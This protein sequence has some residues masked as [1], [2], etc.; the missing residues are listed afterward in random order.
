MEAVAAPNWPETAVDHIEFL[1]DTTRWLESEDNVYRYA[2]FVGRNKEGVG[3]FPHNGLLAEN[4]ATTALGEVY[5]AIP[6]NG[7]QYQTEVNI[8]A[9]GAN[10]IQ[11]FSYTEIS[12][13]NSIVAA[14]ADGAGDSRLDFDFSIEAAQTYQLE[15]RV[16]SASNASLNIF[17]GQEAV[18]TIQNINTGSVSNWQTIITD[19]IALDTGNNSLSIATNSNILINSVKLVPVSDNSASA[20]G[21]N[22]IESTAFTP[23]DDPTWTHVIPLA[24]YQMAHL[25][26]ARKL[27]L[28]ISLNYPK[29]VLVTELSEQMPM[30]FG[31]V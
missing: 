1:A 10:D 3:N 28:L 13:G 31:L 17:Q 26:R 12:D 9:V 23:R 27:Y 30:D 19:P 8:P 29:M 18:Q 11:G 14:I 5:F 24:F 6:S 16:A 25:V 22:I 4:G 2:W 15:I 21:I 20:I 7:Y